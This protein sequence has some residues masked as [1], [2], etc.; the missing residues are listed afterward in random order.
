MKQIV[1]NADVLR[2][3]AEAQLDPRT[4]KRAVELGVERLHA[5]AAKERLRSAAA[6]LKVRLK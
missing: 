3:A 2:L 4:V 6:K 1:S 5:I